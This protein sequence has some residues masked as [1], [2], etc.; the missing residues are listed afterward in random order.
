MKSKLREKMEKWSQYS[1]GDKIYLIVIYSVM[2]LLMLVC[3]YPLYFT[4]IASVSDPDAVYTGKVFLFPKG[5]DFN[6]YRLVFQNKEIWVGYAN[7]IFYTVF[8]TMFNLFL[9]IPAAYALSKKRMYGLGLLTGVFLF[10]MYFGGGMIPYYILTNNLHL[11]NTRWMLILTGGISVYNVVVTRTYFA[12][13]IPEE[14]C[15]SA[16][17][18]GANELYIFFKIALPLSAP[19]IAVIALYYAVGHWNEYFTSLIYITDSAKKPLQLILRDILITNQKIF[20]NL[21]QEGADG[22]LLL[23]FAKKAKL[24][25]TMKYALVFIASAPMLIIYP[26]VQ[27]HFVK[28]IMVGSLKG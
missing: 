2:I 24:A 7:T 4:V 13:S 27:K 12:N 6:S 9:T 3:I 14:L 28:G 20:E 1:W 19:I 16:K 5:L 22:D 10:T 25:V 18:D 17:M 15:E 26:F 23:D 21:V 11:H 8:G